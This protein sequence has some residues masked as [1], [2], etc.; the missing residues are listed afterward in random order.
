[1]TAFGTDSSAATLPVTIMCCQ[2]MGISNE[3]RIHVYVHIYTCV[4]MYTYMFIHLHI[5]IYLIYI[6]I[7]I[8]RYRS[9]NDSQIRELQRTAGSLL[10][11][12][13]EENR[14]NCRG[15]KRPRRHG[16]AHSTRVGSRNIDICISL[17]LSI[18][19]YIYI[20]IYI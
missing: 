8:H 18:Y 20:Y 2:R 9:M 11:D 15:L 14:V 17:S 10:G 7:Y 4:H 19:I 12:R 16:S 3:V 1:M 5:Y 6:R 13:T